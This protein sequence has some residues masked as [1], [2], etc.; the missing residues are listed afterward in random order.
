MKLYTRR[1]FEWAEDSLVALW[2]PRSTGATGLTAMDCSLQGNNHATAIS[3]VN[4]SQPWIG[5]Q[6]GTVFSFNGSGY[7]SIAR[8][9]LQGL[10]EGSVLFW[11]RN[12]NISQNETGPVFAGLSENW[13]FGGDQLIYTSLLRGSNRV[14]SIAPVGGASALLNWNQFCCATKANQSWNLF[15]NTTR[16]ATTAALST[17]STTTLIG[18]QSAFRYQGNIA[19]IALYSRQLTKIESDLSFAA[20]PEGMW[21]LEPNGK[22]SYFAQVTT[23][24]N[25]WFR[26]QQH[27]I[28]GGIR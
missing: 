9:P 1:G 17:I 7:F 14:N 3:Y 10:S 5:S 28:G 21:Q 11:S 27:M 19:Y 18:S 25:Y 20:G 23:F 12:T 15:Q 13:P 24:K 2:S 6:F 16:I 8:N 26:S 22:R 4:Q